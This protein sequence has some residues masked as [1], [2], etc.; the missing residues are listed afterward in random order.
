[1]ATTNDP[2]SDYLTRIRN[3]I[4][5]RHESLRIPRTKMLV[6]ITEILKSE[7]YLNDF[8]TVEE[9][10]QG[11]IVVHLRYLNDRS[12]AIRT[13]DRVS[14]P[15]RRRYVRST[16]IP[17]IKNGLGIAILSTSRGVMTGAAARQA[18]VGGELLCT[19][20]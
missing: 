18:N 8:E 17:R 20:W 19:V 13:L 6:R 12:N 5:A 3:A 10:P 14:K 1:M 4:Q 2:I 15:S 16:E 11:T 9:G 7:G